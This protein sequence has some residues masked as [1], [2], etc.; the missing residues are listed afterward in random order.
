VSPREFVVAVVDDD[1]RILESLQDLLQSAGHTVHLFEDAQ[2][3]LAAEAF[4][5]IDC[6]ISDIG[7]PLIDG[8]ELGR[9]ARSARP[10][11]PVILITGRRELVED[12]SP[13]PNDRAQTYLL[14]PFSEHALLAAIHDTVAAGASRATLPPN[15]RTL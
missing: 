14:K 11:L 7:M 2:S 3:L 6:L 1:P 4:L 10:G 13:D 15:G 12:R 8:F 5:E 9:L